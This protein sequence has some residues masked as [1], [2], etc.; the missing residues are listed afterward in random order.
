VPDRVTLL[1]GENVFAVEVHQV[2]PESSDLSF[3][4]TSFVYNNCADGAPPTTKHTTKGTTKAGNTAKTFAPAGKTP[5]A[6]TPA[7][8]L[9]LLLLLLLLLY[10]C[11]CVCVCVSRRS[12]TRLNQ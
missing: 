5:A 8:T 7:G 4:L 2:H 12:H 3:D 1:K 10:V 6:N 9:L 11:V